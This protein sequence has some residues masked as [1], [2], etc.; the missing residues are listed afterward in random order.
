MRDGLRA[1]SRRFA[2][3]PIRAVIKEHRLAQ[4]E[5]PKRRRP[6]HSGAALD[7]SPPKRVHGCDVPETED[8]FR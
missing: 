3:E 6:V 7:C 4:A 1:Q 8:S 2:F 5:L